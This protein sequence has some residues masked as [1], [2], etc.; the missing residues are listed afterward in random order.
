MNEI[1]LATILVL[2]TGFYDQLKS[3]DVKHT[4]SSL[5]ELNFKLDHLNTNEHGEL[6]ADSDLQNSNFI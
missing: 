2:F 1:S 6:M 3:I 4:H 5:N